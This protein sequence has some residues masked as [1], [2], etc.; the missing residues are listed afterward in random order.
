[1]TFHE[2]LINFETEQMMP[3]YTKIQSHLKGCT[4][5]KNVQFEFLPNIWPSKRVK[6]IFV[7][8]MP[9]RPEMGVLFNN[10]LYKPNVLFHFAVRHFLL[11]D[12]EP[13]LVTDVSKIAIK[14]GLARCIQTHVEKDIDGIG[15]KI[16]NQLRIELDQTAAKPWNVIF[17][18][19]EAKTMAT[20]FGIGCGSPLLWHYSF[21]SHI[22]LNTSQH[23]WNALEFDNA[24]LEKFNAKYREINTVEYR[25]DL[26]VN[27]QINTKTPNLILPVIKDVFF[28][29]KELL[30]LYYYSKIFKFVERPCA[31]IDPVIYEHLYNR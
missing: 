5:L 26:L 29:K 30:L 10:I 22:S 31:E 17:V 7:S 2:K 13:Y 15:Q 6:Y 18:K 28:N 1:M 16:I 20:K 21:S 23:L 19:P 24:E 4:C 12:N 11:K 8:S 14:T 3:A 25:N 27:Y 9:S